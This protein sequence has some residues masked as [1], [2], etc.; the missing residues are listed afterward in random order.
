VAVSKRG[1]PYDHHM[2]VAARE[3]KCA[4]ACEGIVDFSITRTDDTVVLVHPRWTKQNGKLSIIERPPGGTPTAIM[5]DHGPGRS[6]GPGT[7][8]RVTDAAYTVSA[9]TPAVAGP[10]TPAVVGPGT[11]LVAGTGMPAAAAAVIAKTAAP[12][13][14]TMASGSQTPVLAVGQ[15]TRPPPPPPP[16]PSPVDPAAAGYQPPPPVRVA[17]VAANLLENMD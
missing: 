3:C 1:G 13:F 4:T 15:P 12:T 14:V 17:A 8:R 9:F 11:P 2:V 16:V 7:Y 10:G 6:G 5:P